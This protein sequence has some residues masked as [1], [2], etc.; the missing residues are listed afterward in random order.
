MKK[1][2]TFL[3]KK[4]IGFSR[5]EII[6]GLSISNGSVLTNALNALIISD[7]IVKYTPFSHSKREQYYKL[8]DP[9][10]LFYLRFVAGNQKINN[11]FWQ[12]NVT[13]HAISSWRGFAFENLCFS[14][15]NQIKQSL[16]I[17]SVETNQSAYWSN[18]DD[19]NNSQIDMII[20]RNDNIVNMCEIKFYGNNFEVDK[21]YDLKLRNR[22]AFIS[23]HIPKKAIIHNTLITTFGLTNNKYS[24]I[25]NNVVLLDDL[26]SN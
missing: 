11:Q 13:S 21:N 6:T 7:F 2:I 18:N 14:H 25:F 5:N 12:N 9:F 20:E 22:Q 24:D 8:V 23:N 15:I 17:L 19:A 26:F 3:S 1:I 4:S 16:G 10:C